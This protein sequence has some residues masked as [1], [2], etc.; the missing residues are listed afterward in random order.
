MQTPR[1][2]LKRAPASGPLGVFGADLLSEQADAY[3]FED[4]TVM[5][6]VPSCF[7]RGLRIL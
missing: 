5:S 6:S 2:R 1:L 4:R 7:H 3:P